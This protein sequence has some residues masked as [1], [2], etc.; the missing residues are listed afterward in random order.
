MADDRELDELNNLE[1][2]GNRRSL[3]YDIYFGEMSLNDESKEKRIE[4]SRQLE[5]VFLLTFALIANMKYTEE[6]AVSYLQQRYEDTLANFSQVDRRLRNYVHRISQDIVNTT[7]KNIDN[8]YYTSYDR[9]VFIAENEAN[10]D[11]NYLEYIEAVK[12]GKTKKKWLD[13]RD[14]RER[15]THI[16]VGGKIKPIDEPFEVGNS[17]M[18]YPKDSSLGADA[19]EIVNCRCSIEYL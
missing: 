3:P 11:I 15:K 8:E 1:A 16:V 6:Q 10:S 12:S 5:A 2:A 4:L 17:L 7:V 9:A 14:K 19:G 18:M 13:I